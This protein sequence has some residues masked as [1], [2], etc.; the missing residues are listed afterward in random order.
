MTTDNTHSHKSTL[1]DDDLIAATRQLRQEENGRLHIRPWKRQSRWGWYVAIP[2]ACLVGF[3]I[4]FFLRPSAEEPAQVLAKTVVVTDTVL[5][6]E[7]VHD[8]IYQVQP[9]SQP[10]T[11]QQLTQ[12]QIASRSGEGKKENVG[13]SVLYDGIRYDLLASNHGR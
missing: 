3:A 5:V 13:V 6:R 9:V 8:T 2:A 12:K 1:S 7:V 11:T 4:G 10:I